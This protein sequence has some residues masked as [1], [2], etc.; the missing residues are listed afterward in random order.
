M[1]EVYYYVWLGG[2]KKRIIEQVTKIDPG[3]IIVHCN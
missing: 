1:C 2:H 3:S